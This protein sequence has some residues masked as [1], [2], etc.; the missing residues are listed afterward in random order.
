MKHENRNAF[1]PKCEEFLKTTHPKMVEWWRLIKPNFTH[2]HIYC[3]WRNMDAQNKAFYEGLSRLKFP[4]SRHNYTLNDKAA[5]LALDLFQLSE[6]GIAL[7]PYQF[8]KRIIDISEQFN[9]PIRWG[10]HFKDLGD[11]NHF[12]FRL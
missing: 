9:Q 6:E 10:G 12:E 11:S 3:S 8:Y 1:C 7:F 5:S 2:V 4:N